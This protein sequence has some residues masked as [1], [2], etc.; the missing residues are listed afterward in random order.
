MQGLLDDL[1]F[2]VA[3]NRPEAAS[4][5]TIV[6]EPRN[7]LRLITLAP[8]DDRGTRRTQ[9]FGNRAVAPA[10]CRLQYNPAAKR[11]PLLCLAAANQSLQL[12]SVL[13]RYRQYRA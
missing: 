7:A 5:R 2:F 13:R 10:F 8:V 12:R 9:R 3:G 4:T 1:R 11:H 6:A